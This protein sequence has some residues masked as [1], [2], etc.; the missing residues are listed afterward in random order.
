MLMKGTPSM[1]KHGRGKSHIICRRCGHRSF[2]VQ[3]G[4]C[5]YCGFG[6]SK[7]IRKY[8]WNR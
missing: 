7:K 1:G 3:K 8:S 4:Y 6:R 5:A 2:N